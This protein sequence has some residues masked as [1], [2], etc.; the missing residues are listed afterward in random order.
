[1]RQSNFSILVAQFARWLIAC[2]VLSITL[3]GLL[4]II[5][6]PYQIAVPA[7]AK[8]Q[9]N[10][11]NTK[12]PTS[13]KVLPPYSSEIG[14][15]SEPVKPRNIMPGNSYRAGNCTWYAKHKRPDLPNN[16]GNANTWLIRARAQGLPTGLTPRVGSIGQK[17][18]HVV[19]V[20]KVNAD[21]TILIT[22]MNFKGVGIVSSRNVPANSF[23]YIY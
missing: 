1:M 9:S 4:S 18:M 7:S 6:S 10:S 17:S 11:S 5:F 13:P 12:T 21:K 3:A 16:L 8:K 14:A 15:N 19:Y 23:A 20:E 22:E 2:M